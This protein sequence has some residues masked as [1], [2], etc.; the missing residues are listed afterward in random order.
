MPVE[1]VSIPRETSAILSFKIQPFEGSLSV[2][3]VVDEIP[4][5]ELVA[6][7]ERERQ[8]EPAGGYGGLV[9][10]WFNYGDLDRY[11][12]G[13]FEEGS[14]FARLKRVYLLGCYCGEVGCW[15]LLARIT[16]GAQSV[17]W[18]YFDQAH[19]RNR[20]Y[21]A[22]GPFVFDEEQYRQAVAALTSKKG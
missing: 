6:A 9:P 12:L 10:E 21:S 22:F 11:F 20:D 3:P 19:R 18:D 1:P 2:T 4:L 15:P 17:V 7:F 16:A 13:D 8:F 5:P 14:Y